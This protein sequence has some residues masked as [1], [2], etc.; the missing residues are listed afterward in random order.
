MPASVSVLP[1]HPVKG[2]V[3]VTLTAHKTKETTMENQIRL[4][5]TRPTV[6]CGNGM[7]TDSAE[8]VVKGHEHI[9]VLETNQWIAR[10]DST[11]KEHG[12]SRVIARADYKRD[13]IKKLNA[14]LQ[15][16]E[17]A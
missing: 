17:I 10:D 8:W 2:S 16:G 12:I 11:R 7:G 9:A 3:S 4:T 5:K 1:Q 14:M 6:W 13:L 15:T